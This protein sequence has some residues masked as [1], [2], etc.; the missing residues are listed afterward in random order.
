MALDIA[1]I[2]THYGANLARVSPTGW[3]PVKCPFH[4]DK[5]ASASVNVELGAFKCHACDMSGDGISLI[6][7]VEGLGYRGA[8][9][10]ARTVLGASGTDISHTT[11]EAKGRRKTA[12]ERLFE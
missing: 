4:E 1:E 12:S 3:R 8:V 6:R 9:D 2:L 10:F 5:V 11:V 7:K